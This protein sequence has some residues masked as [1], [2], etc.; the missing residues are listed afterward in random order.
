MVTKQ[1][2]IASGTIVLQYS[3]SVYHIVVF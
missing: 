3:Y 1:I 2:S